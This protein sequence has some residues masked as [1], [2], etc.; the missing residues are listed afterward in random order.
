M[1]EFQGDITSEQITHYIITNLPK[2]AILEK[3][4]F[5]EIEPVVDEKEFCIVESQKNRIS[6]VLPYDLGMCEN[7]KRE[8][9]DKSHRHYHN[10]FISCT[11]CGPRYTII[12]ALP[13]DRENTSMKQF[14]FCSDC[15]REYFTPDNRRFNAQSTTCPVCGPRLF[16]FSFGEKNIS[17]E[18]QLNF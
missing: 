5:Y 9:Y 7:C 1:A 3:I 6:T 10:V 8:F 4:E 15:E 17:M 11:D 16:L 13:Y 18:R 14:K 12:E 2:N